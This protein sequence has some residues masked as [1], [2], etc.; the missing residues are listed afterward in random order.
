MRSARAA[1]VGLLLAALAP[2]DSRAVPIDTRTPNIDSPEI[3]APLTGD[4][5]FGHRF[6][7]AGTKLVNAPTFTLGVGVLTPLEVLVRYSSNSDIG[8]DPNE[9]EG[10]VKLALL[11]QAGATIDLTVEL[12]YNTSAH[13]VDGAAIVRRILFDRLMLLGT[14]R[15]FSSAYGAGGA[16][17]A[18]GFGTSIRLTRYLSIMGDVNGVLVA[19]HADAIRP[20]G[21]R[22]GWSGGVAVRIP[23]TPHSF[24]FI[25]TNGL[26]Q[27]LQ[28]Q[29]RGSGSIRGGFEFE[30]LFAD[31]HRWGE[32]FS[33][34]RTASTSTA[35]A[36]AGQEV[37]IEGNAYAP[38][39]LE[40]PAG[41][42]VAW[43]NRDRVGHTVS[44]DDGSFDSGTIDAGG[45][46]SHVF[47]AAGRHPYSCTLH[48]YM[49]GEIVVR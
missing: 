19:Q 10:L 32:I 36:S 27:T 29:S 34:V 41:T 15:G 35:A 16:T 25:A 49:K 26:T 14:L 12:G 20:Q 5:I 28:G 1:A 47:D 22:L 43:V 33:A 4:F 3:D 6:D 21:F 17:M 30:I 7:L 48:P 45:S 37:V 8:S 24:S 39:T 44:A 18:G 31:A 2:R 9:L 42:R 46:W 23:N 13:S 38:A 40:V 11:K